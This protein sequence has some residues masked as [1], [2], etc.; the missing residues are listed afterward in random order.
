MREGLQRVYHNAVWLTGT[1]A[2]AAYLFLLYVMTLW[3]VVGALSAILV[4]DRLEAVSETATFGDVQRAYDRFHNRANAIWEEQ[5]APLERL[6]TDRANVAEE[7]FPG[8][9]LDLDTLRSHEN[10]V[11]LLRDCAGE[12]AEPRRHCLLVE[13]FRDLDDAIAQFYVV[14]PQVEAEIAAQ[15]EALRTAEPL[16]RMFDTYEFFE[17]DENDDN[18]FAGFL[19][20]PREILVMLLTMVMGMLGSVVTMTWSFVRRDSGLTVRRFLI[21]PA[22]GALSAFIV[23]IFA[24]AGQISLTSGDSADVL[25]PYFLSFLGIISGLLSER[26]Y[27]R[28]AQ[29]GENFFAVDDD[30]PRW[31]VRIEAAM[32]EEGVDA[33][34]LADY[35]KIAPNA[36]EDVLSGR[37]QATP[38]QQLVI[39]TALRRPQRELFTDIAPPQRRGQPARV[40]DSA[41]EPG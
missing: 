4:H 11:A 16:A 38:L 29:I 24:K 25:N 41:P 37:L 30:R 34:Q 17:V 35:L 15:T 32:A 26:A 36:A 5:H 2:G 10:F 28:I 19:R 21:L 1:L 27:A 39:A 13:E 14:N 18:M 20:L 7:L 6:Y 22:V 9:D 40:R 12:G 8:T 33:T 3:M 31:G 23:L